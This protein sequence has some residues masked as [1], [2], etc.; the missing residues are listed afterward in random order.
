[1][2]HPKPFCLNKKRFKAFVLGADPSNFSDHGRPKKFEFVFGILSDEP[3]YFIGILRNLQEIG[4]H[5]ED[6]YVQNIISE[7]LKE[8]TTKNKDWEEHAD[9]WLL[10]LRS[11]LDLVDPG[12]KNPVLITAER[13]MRF[14]IFKSY[15]LPSA[16]EIYSN[17]AEVLFCIK[18]KDNKLNRPLL[19]F[20]R[21]PSY[22]LNRNRNYC[23]LLAKKL[24]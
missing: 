23:E 10:S 16:K 7:Y 19:A 5:L 6:V 22:S 14:L 15:K 24:S 13:I 18:P 8:E 3:R 21:H 20:Y 12:R 2:N 17:N 11:E 1:M 4:L 9:R